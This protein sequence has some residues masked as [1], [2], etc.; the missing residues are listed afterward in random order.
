[1]NAPPSGRDPV[2][3]PG[4][5]PGEPIPPRPRPALIRLP[6]RRVW[7]VY[8]L[9]GT[10]AVVFL[11]QLVLAPQPGDV[12]PIL[13]FGAKVN[14]L[15]ARG[16]WWRLVTPIFIHGS[17]LHFFFNAYAL[18]SLGR[19]IER[20]YGAA[21]FLL[22]FF[23]SGVAGT[24]A[25]LLLSPAPSVGASGAI[26]GLIGAEA[27]L[28]YRNRRLL[29]ERARAGLQNIL[30]IAGINLFI[31]FQGGLRIDNWA[32]LGGLA[33]GLAM[34]WIIGPVW[35][36]V[37]QAPSGLL[38]VPAAPAF[39]LVDQQAGGCASWMAVAALGA[40]LLA[41]IVAAVL[42]QGQ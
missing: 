41:V 22:L 35:L 40:G 29:G 25:S 20:F 7:A 5:G 36:P 13:I 9:L 19:E 8:G 18:Y 42:I 26:F 12:D 2:G 6:R 24:T 4:A 10:I 33:G 11:G 27:V 1:V 16:E 39:E 15:I 14:E 23:Y 38:A 21:R 31:G 17:V 3:W 30:L 32:H 37:S 28:L 34:A